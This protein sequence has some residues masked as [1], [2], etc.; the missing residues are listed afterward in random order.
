[1]GS[2]SYEPR[3]NLSVFAGLIIC[4]IPHYIKNILV[5]ERSFPRVICPFCPVFFVSKSPNR[6]IHKEIKLSLPIAPD[7]SEELLST[8]GNKDGICD[9]IQP[10]TLNSD[11]I[12]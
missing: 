6:L 1:M 7:N 10:F 8:A 5:L 3:E 2:L 11:A 9:H 12:I 4:Q